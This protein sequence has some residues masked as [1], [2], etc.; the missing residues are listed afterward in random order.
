MNKLKELYLKYKEIINYLFF[1]VLATVVSLG[2][3][4]LLLFTI[5]DATNAFELQLSV[6]ISWFAAC[7]FAYITNRLWVFESK[8]KEI[9]KEVTKFFTSRLVT[10]G[11]EMLIMFIFVTAL[12]LN[13]DIWVIV[14]TLVAQIVVIVGNYILSKLLVFKN[15]KKEEEGKK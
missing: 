7:T 12:G 10:L 5:L 4:Y 6:I 13:S 9:I 3:K 2:V 8:S 11:L 14:W 1:G 15:K